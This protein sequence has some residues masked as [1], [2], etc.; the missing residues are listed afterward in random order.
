MTLNALAAAPAALA[1]LD[2]TKSARILNV[3]DRACNLVNPAGD[4]L[5]LVLSERGLTPF[6]LLLPAAPQLFSMLSEFS[7][8]RVD[9]QRLRVGALIVEWTNARP[10]NPAPD[11]AALRRMFHE[12][13]SL[14]ELALQTASFQSRGSLLELFGAAPAGSTL[15]LTLADRMHSGAMALVE[16]LSSRHSSMA[17]AGV[18]ALAGVGGGLTPAGDDFITG[19]LLAVRAGL[20][21]PGLEPLAKSVAD[22]AAGRTTTLSGAYLRAAGRGEC[23]A[24]WHALFEALLA[25]K[26]AHGTRA[27]EAL[28]AVGHTSGGDGLAGFLAAHFMAA[29]VSSN[30]CNIREAVYANAD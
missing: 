13:G 22:V 18:V 24:P 23:S 2:C 8:V 1:W 3:F 27:L 17:V 30:P 28:L 20:Y 15:T 16:G 11:W 12:M 25:G 6:A 5:T 19:A 14:D 10:W 21:G 9:G 4:A 29:P 7:P 26:P